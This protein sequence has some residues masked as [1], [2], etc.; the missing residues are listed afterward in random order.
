MGDIREPEDSPVSRRKQI[1]RGPMGL[2]MEIEI[3]SRKLGRYQQKRWPERQPRFSREIADMEVDEGDVVV[4]DCHYYGYPSPEV[5]WFKEDTEV[6]RNDRCLVYTN[7]IESMLVLCDVT[8]ND[9]AQY[10]AKVKNY[11]ATVET[12]AHLTVYKKGMYK[13]NASH[14]PGT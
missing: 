1:I 14:R 4:F 2:P 3:T 12:D 11:L 9:T 7:E 8:V 5:T 13:K 10:T 6:E